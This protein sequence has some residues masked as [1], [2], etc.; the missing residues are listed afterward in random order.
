MFKYFISLYLGGPTIFFISPFLISFFS[1][2]LI[3]PTKWVLYIMLHLLFNIYI[4]IA[5][6][7]RIYFL[8]QNL[9]ANSLISAK[10]LD[11]LLRKSLPKLNS[12]FCYI[13]IQS[14]FLQVSLRILNSDWS[15][16]VIKKKKSI[17]FS[18]RLVINSVVYS[19]KNYFHILVLVIFVKMWEDQVIVYLKLSRKMTRSIH[20]V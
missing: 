19:K 2:Y 7:N 5:Y 11:K 16:Q 17:T 6:L 1:P 10:L 9:A 20:P 3:K 18:N 8:L 13:V 14:A 12:L 4:Y 15:S